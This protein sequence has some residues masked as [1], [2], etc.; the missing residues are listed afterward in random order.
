M[1]VSVA[2]STQAGISSVTSS[3]VA[4]QAQQYA[5]AEGNILR[6]T[7]YSD[8]SNQEKSQISGTNFYKEISVGKESNYNDE[9]KEKVVTV[10]IYKNDDSIPCY[11]LDV[12]CLSGDMDS[13]IPIGTVITWASNNPPAKG[14][15][16]LECNGQSCAAYPKLVKVLGQN[17]VPDYRGKFLET[18]TTAGTVLDAGLPDITGT[19]GTHGHDTEGNNT[20]GGNRVSGAFHVIA[21]WCRPSGGR[22]SGNGSVLQFKASNSNSIYGKSTTVQPPSVTVR[23]FIRA[24]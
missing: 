5:S 24:N 9:I 6:L 2:K 18:S 16:W 19:F 4:L 10:K 14:G 20:I 11:T 21:G 3:K 7:S 13:G 15:T 23:R 1:A 12:P 17:T 8:L 22:D